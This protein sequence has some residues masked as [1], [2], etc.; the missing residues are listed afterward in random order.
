MVGGEGDVD[1]FRPKNAIAKEDEPGGHEGYWWL[2]VSVSNF[3]Y[4]C[5]TCN[6][7]KEDERAGKTLGKGTRF[8]LQAGCT[9]VAVPTQ[10]LAS[11]QP[12]LLD[13]T[14]KADVDLLWFDQDGTVTCKNPDKN[15]LDWKRVDAS[16]DCYHLDEP[17]I[18]GRRGE[19]CS[20]VKNI[21]ETLEEFENEASAGDEDARRKLLEKQV[22][23]LT[24]TR[25]YA[26]FSA[27]ARA[28]LKAYSYIRSANEVLQS[29]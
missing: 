12:L 16:R 18:L 21:A 7:R 15:S 23:L 11:E 29:S 22:E 17:K 28:T 1:H 4:S 6:R 19:V 25:P 5:Q 8:P 27:A 20:R 14:V 10:P 24:M 3:R 9:R 13:S 26:E 2:G